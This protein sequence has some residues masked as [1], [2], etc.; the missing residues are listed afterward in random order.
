[1]KRW[2]SKICLPLMAVLMLTGGNAAMAQDMELV[3]EKTVT[4]LFN[5]A[6]PAEVKNDAELSAVMHNFIYGDV[7]AVIDLTTQERELVT[8]AVLAACGADEEIPVHVEG[9][10]NAGAE[11]EFIRET[12]FQTTPY[13]GFAKAK[14]ALNAMQ[15]T[16]AQRGISLPLEAQ[17]TVTAA[18]RLTDGRNRQY[19]IFGREVIDTMLA[20][21]PADKQFI[22]DFLSANCFGDFYTRKV[23]DVKQRELITFISIASLGGCEAQVKAHVQ[24]NLAVGNSRKQ[25]LDALAV[26][27]PYI[28]YPRTLNAL[29]CING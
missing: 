17:G 4:K 21:T 13:I 24:A 19:D 22:N 15:A 5:G 25:L 16:F 8:L 18:S 7:E 23:L 11:P 29:A 3:N 20:N 9:A 10:L 2:L 28:G 1:M 6:N 26:A 14:P 12:L 27:L